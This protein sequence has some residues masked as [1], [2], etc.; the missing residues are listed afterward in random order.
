MEYSI[1]SKRI[2]KPFL[3]HQAIIKAIPSEVKTVMDLGCGEEEL[4]DWLRN[5]TDYTIYGIDIYQHSDKVLI[6][7]I[8]DKDSFPIKEVDV[9]IC[10]QVLEHIKD[11]QVALKNLIEIAQKKVIIT[12]PWEDSYLDPGHINF[13]NDL[14]IGDFEEIAEPYKITV[15]KKLTKESDFHSKQRI[16]FIEIWKNKKHQN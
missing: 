5:N 2:P 12:I 14:N 10:S 15:T 13:W 8:V 6:G 3:K 4:T 1:K 11:W 7:D 9:I 16:Y